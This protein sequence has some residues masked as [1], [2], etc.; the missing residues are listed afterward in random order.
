MILNDI[1]GYT[2]NGEYK[3]FDCVE[4]WVVGGLIKQG[5]NQHTLETAYTIEDQLNEFADYVGID[6]DYVDS[7]VFP[8]PFSRARAET[9]AS[10]A[11]YEGDNAPR[12]QCGNEF[13][14]I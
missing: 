1:A 11:A 12:C 8:V 9:E 7:N 10:W 4:S 3:C 5:Y 14:E 6:R 13:T 2:F